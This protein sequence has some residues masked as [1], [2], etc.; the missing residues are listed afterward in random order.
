MLCPWS[1]N[2][3]RQN[4][5]NQYCLYLYAVYDGS[6]VFISERASD[7]YSPNAYYLSLLVSEFSPLL[8][9]VTISGTIYYWMTGLMEAPG[10]FFAFLAILYLS[11]YTAEVGKLFLSYVDSTASA[12]IAYA[13][14]QLLPIEL[15]I[16]QANFETYNYNGFHCLY[17]PCRAWVC[18]S[19]HSCWKSLSL[20]LQQIRW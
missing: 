7:L 18:L 20:L 13:S 3:T 4:K 8:I 12:F 17:G 19:E 9:K 5:I 15:P 14:R 16:V 10:N 6:G 2:E 1:I 11:A